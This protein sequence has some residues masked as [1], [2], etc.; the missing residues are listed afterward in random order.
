VEIGKTK[1]KM[2]LNSL[3]R[4]PIDISNPQMSKNLRA[5]R[6]NGRRARMEKRK[7]N[8]KQSENNSKGSLSSK[9]RSQ[10]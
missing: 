9:M 3:K 8:L 5:S 1:S 7:G 4:N 2:N 6:R 10:I